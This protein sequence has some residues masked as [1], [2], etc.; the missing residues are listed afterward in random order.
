MK[1]GAEAFWRQHSEF[2]EAIAK[3]LEELLLEFLDT[4]EIIRVF[5]AWK[6]IKER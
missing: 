5:Q 6:S 3:R 2:A 4:S 1:I